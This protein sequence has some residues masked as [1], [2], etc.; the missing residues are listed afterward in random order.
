M[1]NR[2]YFFLILP[3][4]LLSTNLFAQATVEAPSVMRSNDKIYVVMAICIVILSGLFLYVFSI[5]KK[6]SKMEKEN[7]SS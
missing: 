7:L 1:R 5:D 3:I 4:L 2:I 6:I